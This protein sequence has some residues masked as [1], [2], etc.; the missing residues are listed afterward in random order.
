MTDAQQIQC[1]LCGDFK[2]IRCYGHLGSVPP[3]ARFA[4]YSCLL[5]IEGALLSQMKM[6]CVRRRALYY[7]HDENGALYSIESLAQYL[8]T[9][10]LHDLLFLEWTS[11]EITQTVTKIRPKIFS[12]N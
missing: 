10:K 6:T 9:I 11:A 12:A 8:G 4:C 2:H 7:L 1:D 5:D 3:A